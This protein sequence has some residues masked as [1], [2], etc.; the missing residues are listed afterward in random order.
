MAF[1][2]DQFRS[3]LTGD[4]ARANLFEVQMHFPPIVGGG[5]DR[6]LTFMCKAAQIPA[7]EV[8]S[9]TVPYFGRQIKVPG[10]KTFAE[11]TI[12]LFNDEDFIVRRAFEKWSNGI[13]GHRSNLRD[14]RGATTLGYQSDAFVTQMGKMG[15]DLKTYRFVGCWPQSVAAIDLGWDQNDAIEEFQVTLSYQWWE[16]DTTN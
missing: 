1:T 10:N 12:T 8:A 7:A 14:P 6:K 2:V 3:E 5:A 9:V 13:N 11:W 4:G 15:N 16:S